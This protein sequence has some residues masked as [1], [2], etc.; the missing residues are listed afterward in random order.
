[1]FGFVAYAYMWAKM[2]K[3]ALTNQDG[4]ESEFYQTKLSV[5][6]FFYQ[7]ELPAT[8]SLS[9]RIKAGSQSIM[10]MTAEQF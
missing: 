7:R 9:A 8:Q 4:G 6:R 10:Q 3:V 5:A 2:A 1:L